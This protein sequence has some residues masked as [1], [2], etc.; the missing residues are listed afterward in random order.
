LDQRE[1]ECWYLRGLAHYLLDNCDQA[2]P[3]LQEALTMFPDE[4]VERLIYEG[5]GFCAESD[6]DFDNSIIPTPV[7]PTPIPPEPIGIF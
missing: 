5:L 1:I 6:P 2:V 7:P 4:N 3:I